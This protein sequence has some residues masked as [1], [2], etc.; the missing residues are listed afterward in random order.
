MAPL[1]WAAGSLRADLHGSVRDA[2]LC[3]LKFAGLPIVWID[4]AKEERCGGC[5]SQFRDEV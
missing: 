5:G 2:L 1:N 3:Q 4:Y